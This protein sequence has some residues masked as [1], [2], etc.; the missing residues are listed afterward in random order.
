MLFL[1]Y[2][3]GL[4]VI[5]ADVGSLSDDI[6]PGETGWVCRPRDA[7]DLARAIDVYFASELF[8]DLPNRRRQIRDYAAQRHSWDGVSEKT[9]RVYAALRA[10]E[11]TA[12]A[13]A[14]RNQPAL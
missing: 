10:R 1:G 11:F 2:S 9:K 8:S 14:A 7:G 13:D 5:A 6:V 3:F 12:D 4:P